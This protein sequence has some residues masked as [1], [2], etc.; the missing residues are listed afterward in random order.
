LDNLTAADRAAF[1]QWLADG[2]SLQQLYEICAADN[3][4]LDVSLTAFRHHL[5]HP[6]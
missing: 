2:H 6:G 3:P 5:R 4:P 1:D